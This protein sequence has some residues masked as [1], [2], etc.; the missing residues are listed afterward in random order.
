MFEFGPQL[1]LQ[2]R[3]PLSIANGNHLN[4]R[5]WNL[6][7]F[8]ERAISFILLS[9]LVKATINKGK[10]KINRPTTDEINNCLLAMFWK[11]DLFEFFLQKTSFQFVVN[12]NIGTLKH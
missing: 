11:F 6:C 1:F 9:L 12:T 7:K 8:D 10:I 3:N 2:N 4:I 5:T